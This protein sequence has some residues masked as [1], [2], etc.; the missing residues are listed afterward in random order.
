MYKHSCRR[1]LPTDLLFPLERVYIIQL[2]W[3]WLLNLSFLNPEPLQRMVLTANC[4][5]I[6]CTQAQIN[7]FIYSSARRYSAGTVPLR[8][9]CSKEMPS[10]HCKGHWPSTNF[11]RLFQYDS[12]SFYARGILYFGSRWGFLIGQRTGRPTKV[13]LYNIQLLKPYRKRIIELSFFSEI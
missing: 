7:Y 1:A 3:T 6:S 12:L 4:C 13:Q 5:L 11:W 2:A 10:M 8:S 9:M